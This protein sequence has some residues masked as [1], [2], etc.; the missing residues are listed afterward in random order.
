[1][2][3]GPEKKTSTLY[4]DK[5]LQEK[6][7]RE[8]SDSWTTDMVQLDVEMQ[9]NTEEAISGD[10][11]TLLPRNCVGSTPSASIGKMHFYSTQ[12]N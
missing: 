3:L 7:M 9:A 4:L 2:L 8:P 5:K 12:N 1:M 11:M 10:H 6:V